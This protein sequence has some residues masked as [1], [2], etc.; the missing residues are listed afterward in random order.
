MRFRGYPST[1]EY[2]WTVKNVRLAE[3]PMVTVLQPGTTL[4]STDVQYYGGWTY[5][6]GYFEKVLKSTNEYNFLEM[7][8]TAYNLSGTSKPVVVFEEG[9]LQCN[10]YVYCSHDG[11][12]SWIY[13]NG[14]SQNGQ[15]LGFKQRTVS[16]A[17]CAN[18]PQVQLRFHVTQRYSPGE[19][20]RIRNIVVLKQ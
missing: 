14:L 13:V 18:K 2:H 19:Y 10:V 4:K 11:G 1:S 3:P 6:S 8:D 20:W 16:L 12:A 15:Y 7:R 17:S 9:Y 5:G